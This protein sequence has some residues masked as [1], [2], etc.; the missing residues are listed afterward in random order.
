MEFIIGIM[1][2]VLLLI[3]IGQLS[4]DRTQRSL[5]EKLEENTMRINELKAKLEEIERKLQ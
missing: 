2:F 5:E 1:V 4:Y 3:I